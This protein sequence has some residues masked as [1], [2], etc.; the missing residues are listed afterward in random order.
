MS[1]LS[2]SEIFLQGC[3]MQSLDKAS[4]WHTPTVSL[5]VKLEHAFDG[6]GDIILPGSKEGSR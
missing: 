4:G 1:I 6:G 2:G 3:S 5:L